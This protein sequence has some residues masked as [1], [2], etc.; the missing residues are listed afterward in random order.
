MEK[1]DT[2]VIGA[3]TAGLASG[4][5]LQE[6]GGDYLII[7][8]KKEIGKP[9]R[10]T[11]G[12]ARYFVDKFNMPSDP[13][14]ISAYIQ[15]IRLAGDDDRD[16]TMDFGHPVG[17]IY[18][19]TKY[20]Q[21]MAH[22]L[23][24]NLR[25][26]VLSIDRDNRI[27]NTDNGNY[28]YKNLII[29]TGPNSSLK[30]SW[31][32]LPDSDRLVAYEETRVIKEK[33]DHD[34]TL[35][36]SEYADGGYVWDFADKGN[37]RRIGLGYPVTRGWVPSKRLAQFTELHPEISGDVDHTIAHQIPVG[38]PPGRAVEN[39]VAWVGDVINTC[40]A[41]TGGGLQ[42]AYW[43]GMEAAKSALNGNIATY[44]YTWSKD[45]RPHLTRH[46]KIK[47]AMYK[48]GTSNL[49]DLFDAMN[50]FKPSSENSTKEILRL[51]WHVMR[52]KP[53]LMP[54]LMSAVL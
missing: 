40:Q 49:A 8:S 3:G 54:R 32:T 38:M 43:S 34:L 50:G 2:I 18:D 31:L 4:I 53:S 6:G 28:G 27:I 47:T 24:I 37:L 22:G 11:G 30:P 26:R 17:I 23:N 52:N 21:Y 29:A 9:I 16:F 35:W 45:I 44:Q 25:E 41:D 20:E 33:R 14:V 39:N 46:Y 15:N 10:S 48:Q 12:I 1:Y 42:T 51:I 19:F 13:S 36:F 7:D 5:T